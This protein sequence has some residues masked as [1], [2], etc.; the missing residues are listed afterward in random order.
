VADEP[1]SVLDASALLALLNLE[2][3]AAVVWERAGS[4]AISSVNW[5]EAYGRLRAAGVDGEALRLQMAQ[6]G[7]AVIA[8]DSNDAEA[9]GELL[10]HTRAHGL[11]LA[12]RACVALA[13]RLG[14]PAVT[15]DRIWKTLDL[16]VEIICIR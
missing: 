7:I 9:S 15:A 3:G 10:P 12:D 4:S 13:A 14:L 5:C 11:S 8:F 16:G 2:P 6:T 1:A